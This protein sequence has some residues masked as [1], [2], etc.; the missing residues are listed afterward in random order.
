MAGFTI[1]IVD[2]ALRTALA[3]LASRLGNMQD[4]MD[5]IGNRLLN[6]ARIGFTRQ[7]AP[8]GTPWKPLAA[9]TIL[10]RQKRGKWPGAILRVQG[11][12]G[13]FGSLNYKPG[14][15]SVEIGA[16]WGN[17]AAYAAIHQFGGQAGR[18]HRVTIPARPYLP[19]SPLPDAY[20]RTCI[21]IINQYLAEAA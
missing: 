10:A 15:T 12:R 11:E 2:A 21:D 6:L 14:P 8:D 18:S 13:L 16:G 3:T 17:S 7:Q 4:V 19:Q 20:L 1:R 9:S 5:D